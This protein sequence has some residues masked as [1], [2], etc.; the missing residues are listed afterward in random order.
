[1]TNFSTAGFGNTDPEDVAFD[2]ESG[3]LF[4]SDGGG[5]E[6]FRVDPVNGV[7]GDGNDVVAHFDVAVHGSRDAEGLGIDPQ[8]GHVLVMD[9]STKSIY[10]LT[11][12]GDLVRIIDCRG[13]PTTNRLYAGVTMAPT[14]NPNDPPSALD[15]WIVD[16]QVDNG[17]DP[18]ENDGKLYEV[19]APSADAPPGV[20]LVAPAEGA[21]VSGTVLLEA[22]AS[23]DIGVTQVAFSVDGTN[24]G[25]DTNGADGWSVTWDTTTAAEGGHTVTAAATDTLGQTASDANGATVDNVASPPTVALTSPAEGSLVSG[26]VVARAT[27]SGGSG[28]VRVAFSVDGVPIGTDSNGAD[29]WSVTWNTTGDS[30]GSHTVAA[31]ATDAGDQTATDTKGV[32]VDNGPPVVDVS[33]PAGGATVSGGTTVRAAASDNQSVASVQFFV[34]GASI[35]TDSSGGDGWSVLWDTTLVGNGG[36]A[37]TAL[38]RDAAGNSTTSAPVQVSVDNAALRVVDAPVGVGNDDVDELQNGT[39]R[40]TGGD[41]E[42]GADGGVPTTIGLR[43]TG[44][45]VPRGATVSRAYVQFQVDEKGTSATSLSVLGE[46]SDNSAA[47]TSAPFNASSRPRTS[48]SVAWQP[49]AWSTLG[50]AGADQRTPD[51]SSVVQEIVDRPGWAAG[52]ALAILVTGSGRRT[53]ESF[54]GGAPPILHIEYEQLEPTAPENTSPPSV[55]GTA[56]VGQTLT[57]DPGTWTGDPPVTYAYQWRRCDAAGEGCT[58]IADATG[59]SYAVALADA[60]A[61]LRVRVTATNSVGSA[62]ATSSQTA[63]VQALPLDGLSQIADSVTGSSVPTYYASNHRVA[64]SAGGRQLAVYGR[65]EEGV[66]LVWRDPGGAWQTATRGELSDGLVLG[67]TGTGDWSASIALARDA[68]GQEHAWVVWSAAATGGVSKPLQMRRLSSLDD[69]AGP[70]VGPIVTL[71]AA[72]AGPARPD[73]AFERAPDGSL[74]GCV[75]WTRLLSG[76]QYELVAAWFSDLS[77]DTPTLHDTTTLFVSTSATRNPTFAQSASGLRLVA[78]LGSNRLQLLS[79]DAAAPLGTWSSSAAGV[80]TGSTSLP[81]AVSLASGDVL[82]AVESDTAA[83]VTTVQRFAAGGGASVD[84]QLSGYSMPTLATDGNRAWLVMIRRSDGVV[85]SRSFSPQGGWSQSDQVEI[86]A[87]GGGGYSWPNV[88]READGRLRFIVRGPSGGQQRSAVLAFQRLL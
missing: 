2:V 62:A 63:V 44:V 33:S 56:E 67:G 24:V 83:Q 5:V 45:Q 48:A 47:F 1:M 34:D 71:D 69:P 38:A 36:H 53:A 19:S 55:A 84:L 32:V 81:S 51:L 41:L 15:Y 87:E 86:G 82:A 70:R 77:S 40:R 29:G 79:H 30:D 66:Q 52:H 37:L 18:N 4:I 59:A 16:R 9:P 46:S 7:F 31:T 75:V 12:A 20:T 35:G 76:T 21:T 43:F 6:V 65:H 23:D 11:R 10:E 17:T 85:V 74:R 26:S 72:A 22:S 68:S 42:L 49:P 64:V 78:R 88:L 80:L 3:H 50:A 13:I 25:T 61:T 54:E 60:G 73:I 14:S 27:A 8:R 28:V 57:A 58:D 39:M